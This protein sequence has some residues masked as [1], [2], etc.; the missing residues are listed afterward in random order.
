MNCHTLV[1]ATAMLIA[2]GW[3]GTPVVVAGELHEAVK[4]NDVA[5]VQQLISKGANVNE[6][7]LFG[8]PLD[9][10]VVRG[11]EQ[12][13]ELLISAGADIEATTEPDMGSDHPLHLAASKSTLAPIAK[14][15]VQHGARVDSLNGVGETP[16]IVAAKSGNVEVTAILLSAGADARRQD[17]RYHMSALHYAAA[18]GQIQVAEALIA[19]GVD[20][21]TKDGQ[22][23]TPMHHATAD[24][25]LDMVQF[26]AKRGA[27]LNVR[28]IK[29]LSPYQNTFSSPIRTLLKQFGAKD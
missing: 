3:T 12:V 22:G 8:T 4:A 27:D 25:R 11:S 9:I 7:D 13:A 26:L 24:G 1:R 10:A 28:N 15:L 19:A 5:R 23:D 16:L 20:I 14:R 6:P 29:G 2:F 18:E 17:G 21:N